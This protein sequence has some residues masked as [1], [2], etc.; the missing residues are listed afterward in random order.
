MLLPRKAP[1]NCIQ[2]LEVASSDDSVIQFIS[3]VGEDE[4]RRNFQLFQARAGDQHPTKLKALR[5]VKRKRG[6]G[7]VLL[8]ALPDK[9]FCGEHGYINTRL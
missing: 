4:E 1:N 5:A 9:D 7:L 8:L 6:R 3:A 2:T